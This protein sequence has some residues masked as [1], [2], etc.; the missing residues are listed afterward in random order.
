MFLPGQINDKRIKKNKYKKRRT[1]GRKGKALCS[2][3]EQ[4]EYKGNKKN[5]FFIKTNK[6]GE[7]KKAGDPKRAHVPLSLVL[8]SAQSPFQILD[9]F[10]QFA[11]VL[12]RSLLKNG[13]LFLAQ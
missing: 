13:K 5:Q 2:L 12:A 6:N 1:R 7:I 8:W 9:L 10:G 3:P 4:I 11:F